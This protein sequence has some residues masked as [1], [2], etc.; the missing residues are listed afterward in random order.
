MAGNPDAD[1]GTAGPGPAV[2]VDAAPA[3]DAPETDTAAEAGGESLPT[4]GV[5]EDA[6]ST[7]QVS[8]RRTEQSTCMLA[9]PPRPARQ[10]PCTPAAYARAACS[11]CRCLTCARLAVHGRRQRCLVCWTSQVRAK[12]WQTRAQSAA[13]D[14]VCCADSTSVLAPLTLLCM[15]PHA[16]RQSAPAARVP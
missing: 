16:R 11:A 7:T 14:I 8:A 12:H 10:L 9:S 5:P 15:P 6:P 4:A 13:A 1:A 2:A 3:S